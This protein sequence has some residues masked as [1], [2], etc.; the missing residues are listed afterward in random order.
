MVDAR[1]VIDDGGDLFDPAL[2]HRQRGEGGG[3]GGVRPHRRADARHR[4]IGAEPG[5]AVDHLGFGDAK[6][7]RHGLKRTFHQRQ[8]A[9]KFVQQ[10]GVDGIAALHDH[11]PGWCARAVKKIPLGALAASSPSFSRVRV[12]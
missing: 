12:S 7:G 3:P 10:A 11:S 9:L 6:G 4:T 1:F 8:V 2:R 5:E